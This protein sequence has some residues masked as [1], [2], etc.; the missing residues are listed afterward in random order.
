MLF[1]TL[2]QGSGKP[3]S[4]LENEIT[5]WVRKYILMLTAVCVFRKGQSLQKT[6]RKVVMK[7]TDHQNLKTTAKPS[8]LLTMALE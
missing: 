3:L 1:Q 7:Y 8:D 6:T 2:E 4:I 5:F